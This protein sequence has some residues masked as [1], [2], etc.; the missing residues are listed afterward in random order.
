MFA[1]LLARVGLTTLKHQI[2]AGLVIAMVVIVP[3]TIRG[4]VN[5]WKADIADKATGEVTNAIKDG[6]IETLQKGKQV[7]EDVL[8]SDDNDLCALLGG[9]LR[10]EPETSA[11]GDGD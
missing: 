4:I 9:C 2:I 10:P 1:A 5:S 3:V 8:Q 11:E 6:Q 7:D